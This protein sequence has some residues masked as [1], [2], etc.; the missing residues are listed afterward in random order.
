MAIIAPFAVE[1]TNRSGKPNEAA[2]D[3]MFTITPPPE[4]L[5]CGMAA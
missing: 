3:A 4:F 1:Y 2:M 5:N